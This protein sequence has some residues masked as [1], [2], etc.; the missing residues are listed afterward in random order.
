MTDAKPIDNTDNQINTQPL[1]VL[2]VDRK[3][4]ASLLKLP[5]Q[6]MKHN[7]T[8]LENYKE[9]YKEINEYSFDLIIVDINLPYGNGIDFIKQIRKSQGFLNVIAMTYNS[10]RELE[11]KAREE[12]VIYYMIKPFEVVELQSILGHI[13]KKKIKVQE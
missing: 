9:A 8:I 12:R 2:I 11:K 7:T 1:E 3:A 10:S 13:L 4:E 6:K 5:I